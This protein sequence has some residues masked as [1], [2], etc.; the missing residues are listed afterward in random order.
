MLQDEV[1][2]IFRRDHFNPKFPSTFIFKLELPFYEKNTSRGVDVTL[3]NGQD[4]H[5]K[6]FDSME[7]VDI[8]GTYK[9]K[10]PLSTHLG[11]IAGTIT[12]QVGPLFMYHNTTFFGPGVGGT[13]GIA[14]GMDYYFSQWFG[15]FAEYSVKANRIQ[16]RGPLDPP[17]N[18]Y[19]TAFT[20]GV[21]TTL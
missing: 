5:G 12:G 14:I 19:T 16:W 13:L 4:D 21:K 8:L 15:F 7:A 1:G 17:Y 11:Y 20:F 3:F 18:Y 2:K 9:L 10:F 6:S